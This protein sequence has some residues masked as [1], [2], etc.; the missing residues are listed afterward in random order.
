M[1]DS[2]DGGYNPKEVVEKLIICGNVCE[3]MGE[4]GKV[5]KCP[6][7]NTPKCLKSKDFDESSLPENGIVVLDHKNLPPKLHRISVVT[8][9]TRGGTEFL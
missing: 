7:L 1:S 8:T 4:E 2:M 5:V 3:S 6:D 9:P